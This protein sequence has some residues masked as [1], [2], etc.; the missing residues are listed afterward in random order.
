MFDFIEGRVV[1]SKNQQISLLTDLNIAF[2][3]D[4]LDSNEFL[5][6]SKYKIYTFFFRNEECLALYGFKEKLDRFI[7]SQLIKISGVGPKTAQNILRKLSSVALISLVKNKD[8]SAMSKISSIGSKAD[9]I[10]YEL[11]NK[12]NDIESY[13]HKY[14]EAF[15]ALINLSYNPEK[16]L[17][18][19]DKLEDGLET[20]EAI[21]KAILRLKDE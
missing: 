7:F 4:V 11:K 2:R 6:D 9:R 10:Y 3:I 1:E 17:L 13:N 16:A 20:S 21:K 15:E 8:I 18:A 19:L 14:H 12:V 5:I